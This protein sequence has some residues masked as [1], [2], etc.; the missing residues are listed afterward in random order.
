MK[1]LRR[2]KS[3]PI[4]FA[5]T[6]TVILLIIVAVFAGQIAPHDPYETNIRAQFSPPGTDGYILGTDELGRDVLSRI[7]F[8]ARTSLMIATLSI[9]GSTLVGGIIGITAGYL[10]GRFSIIMMRIVDVLMAIPTLLIGISVVGLVGSSMGALVFALA[11]SFSPPF[12]RVA[13]SSTKSVREH[14]YI[15]ASLS[16]GAGT[17]YILRKDILPNIFP[18]LIVQITVMFARVIIA[19]AGLG[20][21]GLGVQLPTASWGGMLALSRDYMYQSMTLSIYPGIAIL[22]AVFAFNLFGDGLRDLLDPRAWQ[23][24][25]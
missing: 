4:A 5:G 9:I 25:K 1:I 12:A 15:E 6:I 3:S 14:L 16:Q 24:D 21:L 17:I 2:L 10:G 8:G 22:I 19:E 23:A 20:F 11:F 7:I 18:L 13:Y